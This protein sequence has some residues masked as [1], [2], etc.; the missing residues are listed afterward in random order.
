[1]YLVEH[2]GQLVTREDLQ[3]AIWPA[4][5]FVEFESGL[6]TA[7]KKIRQVLSDSADKPVYIET[8]F[9]PNG[10][11]L[12][13]VSGSASDP[14]IRFQPY[15]GP[16]STIVVGAGQSPVW[17]PDGRMLYYRSGKQMMAASFQ[18]GLLASPWFSSKGNTCSQTSGFVT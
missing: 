10:R 3:S 7:I 15:P 5:T 4:G 12:A 17:S 14:E 1:M 11:W 13:Y 6:N 16:G 18:P 2:P 8:A 9:S